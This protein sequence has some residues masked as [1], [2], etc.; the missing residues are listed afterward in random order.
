MD[1][2]FSIFPTFRSI[3]KVTL[4]ESAQMKPIIMQT[5]QIVHLNSLTMFSNPLE[6]Q[7]QT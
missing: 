1:E 4:P 2:S 6:P 7:S 5:M 3:Y